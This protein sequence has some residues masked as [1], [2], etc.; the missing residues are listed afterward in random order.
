MYPLARHQELIL[1]SIYHRHRGK[2]PYNHAQAT[3]VRACHRL[4]HHK[5]QAIHYLV[6]NALP[7]DFA[8]LFEVADVAQSE[9]DA[10]I[11]L[12]ASQLRQQGEAVQVQVATEPQPDSQNGFAK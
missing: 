8:K 10:L 1:P 12:V 4:N 6:K 3:L 9:N 11:L 7:A 2:S 5:D